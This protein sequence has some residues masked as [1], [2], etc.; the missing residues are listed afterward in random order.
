MLR[1]ETY[2]PLLTLFAIM[3][4]LLWLRFPDF[5]EYANSRVIEPWGDGYKTYHALVYHTLHD[6]TLT[7]FN[8]MNYPY[9]DH[10][11]PGDCQPILSNG[12]KILHSLGWDL[13]SYTIGALHVILLVSMVLC[14]L[15]LFLLLYRFQLPAWYSVLVAI[16]LTFLAP[17]ADRMVSHFGLAHPEVIPMVLYF[18]WRWHEQPHWKWSLG[19]GLTVWA[20]SLFHFYFFAILG[21]LIGGFMVLRWVAFKDWRKVLNYAGHGVLMLGLPLLFFYFWMMHNDPIVDR[22]PVPWGFF[23]YRARLEGVFTHFSQIQWRGFDQLIPIRRVDMEANAYIGLVATVFMGWWLAAWFGQKFRFRPLLTDEVKTNF[24]RLLGLLSFLILLFALGLPFILPGG[25]KLLKYTGP[26]QQF[27]SIGRFAWIFYYGI[28]IIAFYGLYRWAEQRPQWGRVV[29]GLALSVLTWE[30]YSYHTHKDLRLDPIEEFAHGQTFT[31]IDSLDFSSYQ[32]IV[33]I[34]YYNIGSGN[35]WW[36]LKGYTGQKSQTLSMQTGLPMTAAMLT[37]TSLSQTLNQFQLVTEPYRLPRIM[38]DLPSDQPLLML[39]DDVR[40]HE[41]GDKFTHLPEYAR[42]IYEKEPLQLYELPLNSFACRLRSQLAMVQSTTDSLVERGGG[43]W[44]TDS[45]TSWY[46]SSFNEQV[47]EQPYHGGG[48]LQGV[49]TYWNRLVDADWESPYTGELIVSFWQYL[50]DDR[51]ARS[52]LAWIETDP[53]TGQ[54]L[55]RQERQSRELVTVFDDQG[56][57]LVEWRIQRQQAQSHIELI[58]TN[59][60]RGEAP[61]YL[62]ELLIRPAQATVAR[63]MPNGWWWNNR[64]YPDGLLEKLSACSD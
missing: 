11:I 43:W 31:D 50:Q 3:A 30:A 34:P 56:W 36:D 57:G 19:I 61:V 47:S 14:A 9:G 20:Y 28:N 13:T 1:K 24:L 6:S 32:A 55:H 16:G 42:L 22:N 53:K 44:S 40:V 64:W 7:H 12:L 37:R 60:D 33:P 58:L 26:I 35:F 25:E 63:R 59:P 45:L 48:G 52:Q 51:S 2:L 15:F 17:Q 49:M 38:A 10:V 39:W 27:R 5:F 8:G 46:A 41:F 21:F 18:L 29:L 4:V 62:D 54:E 23:N